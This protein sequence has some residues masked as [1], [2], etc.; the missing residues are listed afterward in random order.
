MADGQGRAL[1]A[2][3][4]QQLAVLPAYR[5]AAGF[6][7]EKQMPSSGVAKLLRTA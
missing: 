6:V 2:G 3:Q 5:R 1:P 4:G 7:V